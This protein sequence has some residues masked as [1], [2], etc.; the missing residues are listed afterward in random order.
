MERPLAAL[1][2]YFALQIESGGLLF[3]GLLLLAIGFWLFLGSL[4]SFG[5]GGDGDGGFWGSGSDG[6]GGKT[7][8]TDNA[9]NHW[10][11]KPGRIYCGPSHESPVTSHAPSRAGL[12]VHTSRRGMPP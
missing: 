1:G 10:P 6:G 7:K 2:V 11:K 12:K 8:V 4:A 5:G 9:W 3:L